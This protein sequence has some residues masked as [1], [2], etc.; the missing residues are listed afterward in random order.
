MPKLAQET[1]VVGNLFPVSWENDLAKEI[2][3]V[4]TG[5]QG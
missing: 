2:V 5:N 3:V 1:L 4:N